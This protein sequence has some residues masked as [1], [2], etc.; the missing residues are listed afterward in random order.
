GAPAVAPKV[1]VFPPPPEELALAETATLTCL[2]SGFF[3]RD[4]LLT[5]TRQDAPLDPRDYSLL[6]PEPDAGASGT[7][8]L[9]SKLS[10]PVEQW[11][12]GDVFTCVVGHDG[13]AVKFIQRSLDR[14]AARP[15]SVNVSV[16][17]ADS[18]L[19]CY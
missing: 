11:R 10:V 15:A 19:V 1:F 6:G 2:A 16:V 9:Y 7:F 18:D 3:P 8:S 5:W 14:T 17:L 4:I 12:R 13:A